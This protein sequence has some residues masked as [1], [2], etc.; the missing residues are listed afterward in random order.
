VKTLLSDLQPDM[1]GQPASDSR[2]SAVRLR[3]LAAVAVISGLVGGAIALGI[4]AAVGWVGGGEPV[5]ITAAAP[6]AATTPARDPMLFDPAAIYRDRAEGV[7]TIYAIFPNP[8]GTDVIARGQGSG[9][10]VS[11]DGYILTSSHVVT[12]AGSEEAVEARAVE[13]ATRI[14]VE[15]ADGDRVDAEIVGWDVFYDLGVIKVDPAEHPVTPLPLGDSSR[16]VVGEPVAAIGSPFDQAGS[17]AVGVVSAV[18]RRVDVLTA[19]RAVVDALQTDAPINRGNSGGPLL[20]ARGEVI[21]INAQIRSESGNAEGVGFAIPVNVA[22][23]SLEQ[24]IETGT[25]R[26]AWL[27]VRTSS[28]TPSIIDAAG[29]DLAEGA[30]VQCVVPGSPAEEG[31][32]RGGTRDLEIDGVSFRAGGDVVI[33]VDGR[34]VATSGDLGRILVERLA[35]GDAADITVVRGGERLELQ[36]ILG[37]RPADSPGC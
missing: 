30:A 20:N 32:L 21:G 34:A 29:L 22:R 7:V 12:N 35:P 26:Y 8:A 11:D 24:L 15:F 9:F 25:V 33:A 27:G 17:L 4:A 1:P 6:V 36:L 3:L 16:V 18:D 2:R 13:P 14:Y 19:S 10:V 37:T 31:E 5:V 23:R 28:L